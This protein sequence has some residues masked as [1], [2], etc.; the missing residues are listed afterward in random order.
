MSLW[1]KRSLSP[2]GHRPGINRLLAGNRVSRGCRE[3]QAMVKKHGNTGI[4]IT[5]PS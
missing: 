5:M 3:T 4:K 2:T 1:P